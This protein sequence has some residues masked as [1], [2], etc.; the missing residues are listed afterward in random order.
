MQGRWT[1][2]WQGS[3]VWWDLRHEAPALAVHVRWRDRPLCWVS[4]GPAGCPSKA[5]HARV[6]VVE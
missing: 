3:P 4:L 1:P 5:A 6:A 2:A